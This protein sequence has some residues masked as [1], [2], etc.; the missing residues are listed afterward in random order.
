MALKVV[1]FFSSETLPVLGS[2]PHQS[3]SACLA[4]CLVRLLGK[5]CFLPFLFILP[6]WG[7]REGNV[8][9]GNRFVLVINV[10]KKSISPSPNLAVDFFISSADRCCKHMQWFTAF[11]L[12]FGMQVTGGS[13]QQCQPGNWLLEEDYRSLVG[14]HSTIFSE[15]MSSS[16]FNPSLFTYLLTEGPASP[17]CYKT[18]YL[19]STSTCQPLL[20]ASAAT[21]WLP[22]ARCSA[23][24]IC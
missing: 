12:D 20:G 22:R 8:G 21:S 23:A 4:V 19:L 1:F 15:E 17:L 10:G 11:V 13:K 5:S 6:S 2:F 24:K 18:E 16:R 3:C 7:S 14:C 9:G